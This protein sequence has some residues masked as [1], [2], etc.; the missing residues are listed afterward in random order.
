M[1]NN[2]ANKKVIVTGH[3]G[4]KGSWLSLWL[5]SL[6]AEVIG[7]SLD[8]PTVPSHFKTLSLDTL[9][10]D[11]FRIDIRDLKAVSSILNSVKPDFVFHLAAQSL[12]KYSYNDPICTWQ[13]NLLGTLN[14]LESLRQIDKTCSAV[15]ITSDKCYENLEW[16]WGYKETDKLGGSDPYSASKA[17]CEI[18]INSHIKSFFPKGNT[19]VRIATARAGN[20]IG[21]GDWAQD[22]LVPDCV[23]AWSLGKEVKLR[24]PDSTRPWQHVLE[25]LSGYLNLAYK[26]SENLNFH[27]E[28]FNFGP[29]TQDERSVIDLTKEMA[30]HWDQ[31]KWSIEKNIQSN[32]SE[33]TLLKLNCDKAL[34][35]LNWHA[36]LGFK[37]T[38]KLTADWYRKFYAK[39]SDMKLFSQSQIDF[40]TSEAKKLGLKWAS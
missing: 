8:I 18:A 39:N 31:I 11:D 3:T 6:N 37:D 22:R 17:A 15:L 35:H 7:I 24:N 36:S 40:Y 21:G 28:S 2:F 38:V 1:L 26:L 14:I 30:L 19:K 27:G 25:P 13:T 20:V 16:V 5:A 10:A 33:S 32:H 12:V 29:L 4:F 23:K 9:L 34:H